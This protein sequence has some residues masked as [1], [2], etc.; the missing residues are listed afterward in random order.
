METQNKKSSGLGLMVL[1]VLIVIV[2]WFVFARPGQAP[3]I[4]N[5]TAQ[6]E[7]PAAGED[8]TAV[9]QSELNQI[10]FGDS[11]AELQAIDADLGQL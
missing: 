7:S 9:I 11:N 5:E 4:G 2:A 8:T 10:D 3:T 1:I 6:V